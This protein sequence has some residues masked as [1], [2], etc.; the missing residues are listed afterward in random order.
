MARIEGDLRALQ[1]GRLSFV[2]TLEEPFG[3]RWL[4]GLSHNGPSLAVVVSG[5]FHAGQAEQS[6]YPGTPSRL[7]RANGRGYGRR[8]TRPRML[9]VVGGT[10]VVVGRRWLSSS[11]LLSCRRGGRGR[12]ARRLN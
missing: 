3:D 7:R 4:V 8:R 6:R 9:V 10:V 11:W 2:R 5:H 1:R 12:G